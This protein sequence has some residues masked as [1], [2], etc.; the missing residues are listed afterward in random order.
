MP[1]LDIS[2]QPIA[3]VPDLA[4]RWRAL[5]ARSTGSFF[6]GWTW[7]GSWL[8]ATNAEP[9]LLAIQSEGRD[10]AL[11]F[12][13]HSMRRRPFGQ[14]ATLW[15]NQSG[16]PTADRVFIEYNGLLA[17]GDGPDGLEAAALEYLCRRNDW[18]VLRLGGIGKGA[19]LLNGSRFRRLTL[20]DEAPAWFI[21]LRAVRAA[22]EGYLSLLSANTRSQIR[23]SAKDYGDAEMDIRAA[24]DPLEAADWLTEMQALNSGRHADNAWDDP[25]FL[26]FIRLLARTGMERGEVEL[27]RISQ[28]SHLLGLLLNFLWRGQALNYQSAFAPALT[29]KSKPGLM[30]HMAAAQRY[31]AMGLDRYS[32]LAGKDR[33]KQSLSTGHDILQ[34]WDLERFSPRLE[35]EHWLRRLLRRPVSA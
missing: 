21:D 24:S 11:A 29:Q 7:M 9:D 6:L 15:L 4:Q 12:M 5:E 28:G 3:Q 19:A 18:R 13:G 14:I 2:L 27:L 31:V 1:S 10:L 33:Y 26:T 20:V 17:A 8:A 23:R 32:L 22:P 35:A 25:I 30:A 16:D 34:W